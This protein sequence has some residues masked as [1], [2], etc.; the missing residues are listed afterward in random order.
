MD[1]KIGNDQDFCIYRTGMGNTVEILDIL[2]SSDRGKGIGKDMVRQVEALFPGHTLFAFTRTSN[3]IARIFWERI[4][5]SGM[6]IEN[7]YPDGDAVLY[8]KKL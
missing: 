8:M 7:F 4:G 2:V 5:F 6:I 3:R 1:Q